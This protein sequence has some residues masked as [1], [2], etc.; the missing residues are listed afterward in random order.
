[1]ETLNW[2]HGF[3]ATLPLRKVPV[4]DFYTDHHAEWCEMIIHCI[5]ICVPLLCWGNFCYAQF[6]GSFLFACLLFNHTCLLNFIKVFFGMYWV[7]H[8][9]LILQFVMVYLMNWYEAT[10]ATGECLH[11]WGKPHFIKLFDTFHVFLDSSWEYFV[12]GV[13]IYVHLCDIGL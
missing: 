8:M 5:L 1:M 11:I 12:E 10:A 9:V 13:C 2:D 6:L 7:D 4:V 3:L